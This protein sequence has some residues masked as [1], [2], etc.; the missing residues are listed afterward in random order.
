MQVGHTILLQMKQMNLNDLMCW[1]FKKPMTF[2]EGQLVKENNLGGLMFKVSGML[3]KGHVVV[4][5]TAS[6]TYEVRIGKFSKGLFTQK[7]ETQTNVYFD[8]LNETIDNL[9][10]GYY[11]KGKQIYKDKNLFEGV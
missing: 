6:D 4:S 2:T 10:E 7:G 1:G 5:L 8:S 11:A 9:V 3:H